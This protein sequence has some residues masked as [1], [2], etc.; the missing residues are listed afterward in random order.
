VRE[1]FS[2]DDDDDDDNNNN[3]NNNLIK[4]LFVCVPTQQP[5][6]QLQSEHE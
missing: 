3:N 4:F 6:D 2:D 5:K 1:D